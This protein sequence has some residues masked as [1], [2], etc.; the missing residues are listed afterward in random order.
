MIG[1]AYQLI[2]KENSLDNQEQFKEI[3]KE[4]VKRMLDKGLSSLDFDRS[5]S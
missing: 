4:L 3:G 5:R 2:F 1:V